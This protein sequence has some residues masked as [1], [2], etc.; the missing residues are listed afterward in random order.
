MAHK[1]D[2]VCFLN[3]CETQCQLLLQKVTAVQLMNFFTTIICYILP[4]DMYHLSCKNR[5]IFYA[6][7]GNLADF[8]AHI[9]LSPGVAQ[10][11]GQVEDKMVRG[12]IKIDT[13][14]SF[15]L[16]LV[17]SSW[18]S[19]SQAGFDFAFLQDF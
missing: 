8:S 10:G 18:R 12:G 17:M 11:Y 3:D 16:K 7:G 4:G 9:D 15:S 14:K 2:Q 1:I 13:E 5:I 19:S 6:I